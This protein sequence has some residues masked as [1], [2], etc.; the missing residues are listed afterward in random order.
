[1]SNEEDEVRL[2]FFRCPYCGG[3]VKSVWNLETTGLVTCTAKCERGVVAMGPEDC[4][5]VEE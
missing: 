2:M 5:I 4:V 1:M 3:R